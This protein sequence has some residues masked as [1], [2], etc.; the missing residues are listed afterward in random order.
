MHLL[1]F[2]EIKTLLLKSINEYNCEAEL[3]LTFADRPNEYMIIIYEE[4]CSFQKCGKVEERSG[5][6][7]YA[8]LD[9]LY[10]AQQMDDIILER[11]W[12]KITD[13][14]CSD[15]DMLRLW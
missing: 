10:R 3:R 5:E 9:E 6:Y 13:I 1:E 7:N 12:N 11:D 4:H 2:E 14:D 8:T 15:F